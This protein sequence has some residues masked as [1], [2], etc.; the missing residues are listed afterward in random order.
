MSSFLNVTTQQKL[1]CVKD[2][3][4]LNLSVKLTLKSV[5]VNVLFKLLIE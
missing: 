4:V 5:K 3:S 1:K 2:S